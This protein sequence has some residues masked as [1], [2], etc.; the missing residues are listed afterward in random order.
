LLII[1]DKN[2]NFDEVKNPFKLIN[3]SEIINKSNIIEI[4]EIDDIIKP[5]SYSI[6]SLMEY[7]GSCILKTQM[8]SAIMRYSIKFIW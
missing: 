3:L 5:N 1:D 4:I 6:N 8:I 7:Y 2:E